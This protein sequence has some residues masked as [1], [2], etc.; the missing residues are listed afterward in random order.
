MFFCVYEKTVLPLFYHSCPF[1]FSDY[2][3][4]ISVYWLA[5]V[6]QYFQDRKKTSIH[7]DV[8]LRST[9]EIK[10]VQTF[11][12]RSGLNIHLNKKTTV[13]AGYAFI[14]NKRMVSNVS[15]Y[16][17]ERRYGSS[18]YII[19]S[20]QLFLSVIFFVWSNGLFQKVSLSIMN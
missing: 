17:P 9:D 5:C 7:A 10:Q 19:I 16:T 13:T 15:G 4:T 6:I 11:L 8:Q 1:I 14:S 2:T 18:Y 12:I 20:C 3:C